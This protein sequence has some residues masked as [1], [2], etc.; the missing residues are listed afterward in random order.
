MK[1]LFL[2][3]CYMLGA[4]MMLLHAQTQL[5]PAS[6]ARCLVLYYT[7]SGVTETLAQAIADDCGGTLLEVVDHGNYPRPESQTTYSYANNERS[8]IDAGV[9]PEIQTSV[10]NFDQWDAVI[11]CTPLWNGKMANPMLTFLHNH[12]SKLE[13]KQVALA[14]TS[15]SSGITNVENDAHNQLPNSTFVGSSLHINYNNRANIPTKAAEWVATLQFEVDVTPSE[16][17]MRVIVG[18]KV[19]LATLADNA[20]AQ[21]FKE[22]LPLTL[23]MT[24]LNGNE[25]YNY[26][27]TTLP[28]D[29]S[30]P[31]TIHAGDI[32][33]YGNSCVVLFYETFNTSY[34][35]TRIGAI[36]D[37]TGLAAA[38][39]TG[40]VTVRFEMESDFLTGDVNSDNEVNIIDVTCLIDHL[41]GISSPSFNLVAADVNN[42]NE[43]NIVDVSAII[44]IILS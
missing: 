24:E 30:N 4:A 44:D 20:T 39:G 31:G 38:L 26:L 15:W 18:D 42:D 12:A 8:Q 11:I 7:Y 10:D 25:K 28:R 29:A 33:L 3:L 43:V 36:D 6:D 37:P 40:D 34:S 23:D 1:R 27:S 17:K 32:M 13:G 9:W 2:F 22:L 14:V 21:A 35:Y 16:P 41:L 19:F 5:V